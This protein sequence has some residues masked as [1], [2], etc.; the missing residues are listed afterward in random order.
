MGRERAGDERESWGGGSLE[1][2]A[3]DGAM[4]KCPLP[5]CMQAE[6]IETCE[7]RGM[8]FCLSRFSAA[9]GE[10]SGCPIHGR[11]VGTRGEGLCHPH[12]FIMEEEELQNQLLGDVSAWDLVPQLCHV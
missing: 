11:G 4:R 12:S 1:L 10:A 8:G 6:R 7:A 9:T 3:G 5:C 2:V